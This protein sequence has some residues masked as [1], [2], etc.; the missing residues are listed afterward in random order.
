MPVSALQSVLHRP[1]RESSIAAQRPWPSFSNETLAVLAQ[2]ALPPAFSTRH[3]SRVTNHAS[4]LTNQQSLPSNHI[5][6][7]DTAC[8]SNLALTLRNQSAA[9][10]S[11][12]HKFAGS[13]A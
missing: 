6:Q 8:H 12:R 13:R 3:E 2:D 11:D 7:I 4:P 1:G 5:V 10:S 9:S